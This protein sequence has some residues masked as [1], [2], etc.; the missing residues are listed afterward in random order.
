MAS[1]ATAQRQDTAFDL[2]GALSQCVPFNFV[3]DPFLK[4]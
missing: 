4:K 3:V 1:A 2:P